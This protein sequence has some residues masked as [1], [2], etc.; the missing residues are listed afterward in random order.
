[1]MTTTYKFSTVHV[2]GTT[3]RDICDQLQDAMKEG[4]RVVKIEIEFN[5]GKEFVARYGYDLESV[6]TFVIEAER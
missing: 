1:M 5:R 2:E 6:S 3:I 4:A